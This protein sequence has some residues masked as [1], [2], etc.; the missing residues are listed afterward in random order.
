[1]GEQWKVIDLV[2]VTKTFFEKKGITDTARLDA[3]LLLAKVLACRRIDLYLRFDEAVG[4]R[5][6]AEFR[7]LVRQ[8]GERRPVKQILGR[9]EFMSHEFEVTPDVLI[10]RPE[11]ETVVEQALARLGHGPGIVID[12]GTGCGN[13]AAS[14]AIERT[15]TKVWATDISEAAL[16]V[17]RRNVQS[18]GL[19]ERVTLLAGD[20]FGPL[21]GRQLDGKTDCIV[22]NPP[23][24]AESEWPGLMPEVAEYEP[25]IALLSGQDGADH[26]LRILAQAA[27]FLRPGGSL[28]IEISPNIADRV[29]AAAESN[30]AYENARTIRDLNKVE[31]VLMAE[32]RMACN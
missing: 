24:I 2:N 1:M 22:S 25:K 30:D 7:E 27:N 12:V 28:V 6:L 10:P 14:I 3:E 31:R 18:L 20:L 4:E 13:I 8:R 23:Y 15:D 32:R 21:A 17:A 29:R 19:S 9:C 5:Q 26:T 11:T 16:E